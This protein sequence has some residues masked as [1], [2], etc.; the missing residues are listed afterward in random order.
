[1]ADLIDLA[2]ERIQAMQQ[3]EL[4]AFQQTREKAPSHFD[5]LHCTDCDIEIPSV[6]RQLG[7]FRCVDCQHH[8]EARHRT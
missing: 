7:C 4:H 1:M 6:R 3:R 5:G 2:S 8:H